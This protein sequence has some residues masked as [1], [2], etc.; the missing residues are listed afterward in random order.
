ML[1]RRFDDPYEGTMNNTDRPDP[2][3]FSSPPCYMHELDP[4][5]FGLDQHSSGTDVARWRKAERKRLLAQRLALP[6][7][8][9]AD[10][11]R[12]IAEHLDALIGNPAGRIVSGYWPIRG[13]PD[14]R[15]WLDEL[16]RRGAQTAL[17]VVVAEA[18]PLVFRLWRR[19]DSLARGVWNI[20]VPVN[21]N[22]V[23]PDIALAPLVGFDGACYRL[24]Y[25]GGFF[26]RTLAQLPAS[27][28]AI[29]VGYA[30]AELATIYPQPFDI[31]MHHIVTERGVRTR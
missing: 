21:G 29:G 27:T 17:P 31:P 30:E 6:P 24:G 8:T 28:I 3:Q 19:G 10:H 2:D 1:E 7:A 11:A 9:R 13:E 26:D 14:L 23:Q 4:A 22:E 18:A 15:L 20:P 12:N 25:G 16:N 5:Y